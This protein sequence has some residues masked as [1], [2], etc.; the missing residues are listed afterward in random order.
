MIFATTLFS[1][2]YGYIVGLV[3]AKALKFPINN[4]LLYGAIIGGAL[5]LICAIYQNAVEIKLKKELR[6]M[7]WGLGLIFLMFTGVGVVTGLL[8]SAIRLIL[9]RNHTCSIHCFRLTSFNL[10]CLSS[11]IIIEIKKE[12]WPFGF[13]NK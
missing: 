7:S 2:L 5:G 13:Y 1:A 10:L 9:F 12:K 8:A 11:H 6:S 3:W 4:G